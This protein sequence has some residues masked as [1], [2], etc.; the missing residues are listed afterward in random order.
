[1]LSLNN[2]FAFLVNKKI[3]KNIE[4]YFRSIKRQKIKKENYDQNKIIVI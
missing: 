1:M 3:D 2:H 4:S